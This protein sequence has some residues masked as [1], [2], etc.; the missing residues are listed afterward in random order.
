MG[1]GLGLDIILVIFFFWLS[2][3][4]EFALL[5]EAIHVVMSMLGLDM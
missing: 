4:I 2:L 5:F 3:D 1:P